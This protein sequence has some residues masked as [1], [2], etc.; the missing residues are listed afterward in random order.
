MLLR[1]CL[2]L[3]GCRSDAREPSPDLGAMA[4]M[5]I[6]ENAQ[7]SPGFQETLTRSFTM[8]HVQEATVGFEP[9]H[10]GFCRPLP[11]HLATSPGEAIS[12]QPSAVSKGSRASVRLMAER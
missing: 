3:S 9:T 2:P 1:C 10:R 8:L 11:Y 6:P 5:R 4:L 7:G 12:F